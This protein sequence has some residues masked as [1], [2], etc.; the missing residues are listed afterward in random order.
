MRERSD[1]TGDFADGNRF[2]RL[3]E[4]RFVALHFRKP[5]RESHPETRRFGVNA[6]RS[7]DLRRVFEFKSATAQNFQKRV[8]F[9]QQNFARFFQK[10]RVRRVHDIARSQPVMDESRR[11]ADVFRQIRRKSDDIVVGRFFDFVDSL[12]RKSRF[13]LYLFKRVRRNDSVLA[14]NFANRD[15]DGEPFLKLIFR[16][17]DRAH[18][19]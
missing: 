16:R 10:Q 15:F 3:F 19:G 2:L 13:R 7:P 17:P 9:N 1:R 4:P 11:R 12:D 6:V 14:V 8:N 18:F 5:E